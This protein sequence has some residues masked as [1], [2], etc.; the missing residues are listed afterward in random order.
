MEKITLK[1]WIEPNFEELGSAKE[2]IKEEKFNGF[3]DGVV[4]NGSPIGQST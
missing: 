4:F 1:N 3:D 2:L